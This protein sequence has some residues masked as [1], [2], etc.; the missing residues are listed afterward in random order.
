MV[1]IVKT[2]RLPLSDEVYEK[3][4]RKDKVILYGNSILKE[5]EMFSCL[6]DINE[7]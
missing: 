5:Y 6:S 2:D 3:K 4:G 7:L 1:S